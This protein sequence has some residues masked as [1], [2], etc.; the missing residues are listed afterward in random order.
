VQPMCLF[1]VDRAASL[2]QKPANRLRARERRAACGAGW[3][4]AISTAI[5]SGDR[6]SRFGFPALSAWW[7]ERCDAVH[8]MTSKPHP[9]P[10]A[11][12]PPLD[13]LVVDDD[14]SARHFLSAAV[15]SLGHQCRTAKDGVE[16]L[17][18]HR[19]AAA[20]VILADWQMP[21][22]DGA[23]LCRQV[24]AVEGAPYTYFIFMTGFDDKEHYVRGMAVGADDYHAKPVDLE[25]LEARLCSA[26]R[27][28]A[29]YKKLAAQNASLR[30]ESQ[31][32]FQAARIDPLTEIPNRLRLSEDLDAIRSNAKR[33]GHRYCAA[34]CDVDDF[35]QYNDHHGHP[36]G[37][38]VLRAI[39]ATLRRQLRPGDGV[40]RYGGEEFLIILPEQSLAQATAALDR[41]RA[42][43]ERLGIPLVGERAAP[44]SSAP[45]RLVTISI[46]VAELEDSAHVDEWIERAD[47]A[48]YRAKARGK[49]VVE[50]APLRSLEGSSP[51]PSPPSSPPRHTA[52]TSGDVADHKDVWRP[53]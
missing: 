9:E 21:R 27:V 28:L 38:E 3:F 45:P 22:M 1:R 16:A 41:V 6:P 50:A 48:L 42:E 23:E 20:D 44:S 29:V 51:Y 2:V 12:A 31:T 53:S 32:S 40:Y 13:I 46:G 19:Q 17:E 30:R 7:N 24:R 34:L 43:V 25:E 49:N 10:R 47:V 52:C 36:A 4:D 5:R 39:A 15:L 8:P 35:K 14:D 18:M 37:D 33:Y 26:Q 11:P